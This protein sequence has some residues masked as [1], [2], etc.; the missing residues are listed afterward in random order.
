MGVATVLRDDGRNTRRSRV[1]LGV[2]GTFT[3][4]ATLVFVS[5]IS[6]YDDP[7]RALFD[8]AGLTAFLFPLF[9][10]PLTYL[11]VA[12]DRSRGS[13]KYALGLPTARWEYLIGKLVARGVVAV[14][15]AL[16]ATF[17][18]FVV[19][20]GAY[21][22]APDPGQFAVFG[23]AAGLYAV[24]FTG[25]FVAISATTASRSRAMFTVI[26]AFFV[27]VPFWNGLLPVLRLATLVDFAEG[28][29]GVTVSEA[30]RGT[31]T[32]LSPTGAFL[33]L[34]EPVFAGAAEEY[35]AIEAVVG[36]TGLGSE[37][38]FN[39]AVL[40]GWATVPPALAYLVFRR[41]ELG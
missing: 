39:V 10:A 19:T 41:A 33:A 36:G 29:L 3:A 31:I 30:T 9:I 40:L 7:V 24:S 22:T 23:A 13:I 35:P 6:V 5:E 16:T 32:A 11:A 4:L 18:G 1:V 38:W 12:G 21:T 14:A 37:V 28:L 34:G 20:A 27:L 26:A 15:A 25:L 17:V 2:V 8:V